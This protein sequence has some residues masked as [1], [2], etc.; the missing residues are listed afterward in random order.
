[1][2]REITFNNSI[3]NDASSCY[4]IAEIGNNHNGDLELAKKMTRL[5]VEAGADCVKFQMRDMESLYKNNRSESFTLL[6]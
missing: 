2:V 6:L 5:A 4:V 3:I 1:M